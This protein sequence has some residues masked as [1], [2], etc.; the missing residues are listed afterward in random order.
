MVFDSIQVRWCSF[1]GAVCRHHGQ[2]C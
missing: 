1:A 2:V